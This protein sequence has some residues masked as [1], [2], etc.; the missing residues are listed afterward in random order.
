MTTLEDKSIW[1]DG[2]VNLFVLLDGIIVPGH[3]FCSS[4]KQTLN[5]VLYFFGFVFSA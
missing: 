1:E 2:Q 3:G 5:L 4:S